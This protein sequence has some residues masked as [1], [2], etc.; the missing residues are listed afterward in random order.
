MEFSWV[1]EKQTAYWRDI[2]DLLDL[3][4]PDGDYSATKAYCGRMEK[5]KVYIADKVLSP[6]VA[7]TM[8]FLKE[9]GIKAK[10]YNRIPIVF[11]F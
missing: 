3:V 6:R 10:N 8:P 11:K 7:A 2:V 4:C 1:K 9:Q 5:L